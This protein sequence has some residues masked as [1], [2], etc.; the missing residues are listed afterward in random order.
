MAMSAAKYFVQFNPVKATLSPELIPMVP[1]ARLRP[2]HLFA[3]H[4]LTFELSYLQQCQS[5]LSGGFCF[6]A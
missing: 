1:R 3:S 6:Q 5:K 2:K 4:W